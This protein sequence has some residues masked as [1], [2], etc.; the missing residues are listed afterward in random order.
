[1]LIRRRIFLE[2]TTLHQLQECFTNTSLSRDAG[3]SWRT[4]SRVT[5]NLLKTK[6]LT[7]KIKHKV[8]GKVFILLNN[9]FEEEDIN[10]YKTND[11]QM[12]RSK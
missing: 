11:H 1:M 5:N 4:C 3:C 7:I 12:D 2:L 10:W 8:P 9:D 6:P